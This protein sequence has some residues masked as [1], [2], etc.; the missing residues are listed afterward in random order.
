MT[1]RLVFTADV[2]AARV[3]EALLGDSGGPN[4]SASANSP[5]IERHD[6]YIKSVGG[7]IHVEIRSAASLSD[8]SGANQNA[9]T[10][11]AI[12]SAMPSGVDYIVTMEVP[13]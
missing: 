3:D 5:A 7:E 1:V 9:D 2:P 13:D 6:V 8:L 4:F 10:E 11:A 12:R